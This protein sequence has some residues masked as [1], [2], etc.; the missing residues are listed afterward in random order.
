LV[1]RHPLLFWKTT[2]AVLAILVLVLL[3]ARYGI[4]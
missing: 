4:R 1:E 2:S 3:A